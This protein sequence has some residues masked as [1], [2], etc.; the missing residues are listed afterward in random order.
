MKKAV[1]FK[2][3]ISALCIFT[4][5]FLTAIL[6]SV[7]VK[8]S[9]D[10]TTSLTKDMVESYSTVLSSKTALIGAP[11]SAVLDS[12][13][14]TDYKTVVDQLNTEEGRASFVNILTNV[15]HISALYYGDE[16]GQSLFIRPL[17]DDKTRS[18]FNAPENAILMIDFNN[19]I[20]VQKRFYYNESS[21]LIASMEYDTN[22]YDPRVR[23]WYIGAKYGGEINVTEPYYFYF[24]EQVG[25]TFSRR[26]QDNKGVIG[27]DFTVTSL[28][29]S[30]GDL[31]I[32]Q[33]SKV[34]LLTSDERLLA[35]NQNIKIDDENLISANEIHIKP[36]LPTLS[37]INP[38]EGLISKKV[39]WEGKNWELIITPLVMSPKDILYLVSFISH[40]EILKDTKA[41][42]NKLI[43]IS[44][45]LIILAFFIIVSASHRIVKPLTYLVD[46]LKNIQGFRFTHKEFKRTNIIEI[47]TLNE[48]VQMMESVL[49]DFFETLR[50]VARSKAPEEISKSLVTQVHKILGA[51][52]CHLYVN[53]PQNRTK[54]TVQANEGGSKSNQLQFLYKS[55]PDIFNT[56]IYQLTDAEVKQA[57]NSQA[58]FGYVIPLFNRVHDNTGALLICFDKPISDEIE[59][60]LGFVREFISFN[61]IV[62][63]HLENA[64]DQMQLFHSFVKM[65]ANAVDIKSPHTGGHC[66]RVPE[67]MKIFAHAAIAD[68]Q[69]F[70]DFSLDEKGWE[71]LMVAAWLHDCGKVATPDAVMDKATKL[72]ATYDRIHEIRM[73][74]EVLKRDA[75]ISA[76]KSQLAGKS[77]DEVNEALAIVL[78]TLDEEFEFVAKCNIGTT[79]LEDEDLR[80]LTNIAKRTWLRTLRDDIGVSQD[81]L[82][83]ID[84]QVNTV[85][86]CTEQ[87][88]VDKPEHLI[89]WEEKQLSANKGNRDFKLTRPEHQ[90]N[91]GELY[92]LMV[93]AGT[94]TTED[95]YNI[96]D[97]IVQTYLML[98][99]LPYPEHLQNVPIIAGSHHEKI[100]GE[101]YPLKLKGDE[102]PLLGRMLAISDIYEAL[103]ASD[104]PYKEAKTVQSALLIMAG[105]VNS[106]HLDKHLFALFIDQ[107]VYYS[108]ANKYLETYQY[109][110]IDI[111]LIKNSFH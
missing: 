105:M 79:P 16:A 67:I 33:G 41:F 108:Y 2:T 28:A 21:S 49:H 101:G 107:K 38:D 19:I 64:E 8:H 56:S 46:S 50:A 32:S 96:N 9:K 111:E 109:A 61:E 10:I 74:F 76:L 1:S 60:R 75:E 39:H 110:D 83:R 100:N 104:R 73:R 69:K 30:L 88:L 65:T 102:I 13:A 7:S 98:D 54:F 34:Y 80:C 103:T 70:A 12:L 84:K 71:E 35:S 59:T 86:P 58:S 53:S 6:I 91:R 14:V 4:I 17:Y 63:E 43:I 52:S 5:L 55:N 11:L 44:A 77:A 31:T 25:V 22:G 93:R 92:S 82:H 51:D 29:N 45:L 37:D 18:I 62:L 87:L 23:P 78:N 24:L 57:T 94:L 47:D 20:G 26:S 81:H 15:P 95:R 72:E 42:L 27:V 106:E 99:Q 97:H 89:K 36:F 85:L 40:S 68:D 48:T 90:Y 66:Q 3:Y